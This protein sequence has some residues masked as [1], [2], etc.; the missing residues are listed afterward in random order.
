MKRP[1][2]VVMLA[3]VLGLAALPARAGEV[4]VAVA[5]N[6]AEVVEALEPEFEA[7]TGHDLRMTTGS[8]GKL[9]AQIVAGAPFD[10]LLSADQD[11]PARIESEGLGVPETRFT[12]ATGQLVLWTQ[13]QSLLLSKLAEALGAD[14]FDFL[15]IA[16]PDLAPYGLAAKQVLANLGLWDAVAGRLVMGQNIGQAFSMVATGNAQ[17]GLVAK[18]QVLSPRVAGTG[19]FLDVPPDLHDPIRQDAILLNADNE[20]ARAFLE[21]LKGDAARQVIAGFGYGVD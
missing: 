16:N 19:A 10:I 11:R 2:P 5:A 4:L 1:A 8:T 18:A 9:Y 6:F 15:A 21:F 20:A 13:D 3:V 12:Y 7:A 14:S 17:L